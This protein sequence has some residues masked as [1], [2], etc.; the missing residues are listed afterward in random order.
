MGRVSVGDNPLQPR[1]DGAPAGGG[2][3]YGHRTGE[4][5]N[6]DGG[7]RAHNRIWWHLVVSY[8]CRPVS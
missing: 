7:M 3:V 2:S 1:S 4:A 8:F 6:R 5:G